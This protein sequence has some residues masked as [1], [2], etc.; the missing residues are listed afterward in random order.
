M[1]TLQARDIVAMM[2]VMALIIFKLTG[3]NGGLDLPIALIVGYYFAK[4]TSPTVTIT[5]EP[6]KKTEKK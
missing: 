1:N 3:H 2:F 6:Y 5:D 4:R